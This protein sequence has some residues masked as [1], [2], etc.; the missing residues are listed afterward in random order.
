MKIN[1]KDLEKNQLELTIE[2]S[3]EELE[4]HL[5]NAAERLSHK[6]KIPGFRPGKV[7]YQLIKQHFGEMNI[8]QEALEHIISSSFY[9]AIT[10]EKLETIGQPEIKVDKLAPGNPVVYTAIVSLLPQV[11]LGDWQKIIVK[12]K[13]VKASSEEIEQTLQ[14]LQE[15]NVKETLANRPAAKGDKV[16]VDFEVLINKVV[17]EGGKSSKYPVIIGQNRMIPG[18]EDKLI[19]LKDEDKTEFELEFPAKYFQTNLAGKKADFK[20]KVLNVF[21]RELPKLDD[22]FAK[23]IGFDDLEK[24]KEQLRENISRDKEAKEK[25]RTEAEAV[26]EIV[27]FS[28]IGE[29]PDILIKNEIQKMLYELEHNVRSQSM[30]IAGYLKSINKTREDLEKDFQPQAQERVKAALILRQ[31]AQEENIQSS[32]QEIKE[33]IKKQMELYKDNKE[34]I[35]NIQLPGYRQHTANLINNQKVVKFISEKIIQ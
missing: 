18:F 7:P 3:P 30:D 29:I 16:E 33:Q 23:N 12:K 1:K 35:K 21:S 9:K 13:K 25:Q 17:I 4:P 32:E 24:L 2:V 22:Q 10:R 11:T 14:Q 26:N 5:K 27:K 31:L 28:T 8:H 19:G 15:M 6:N 20:V 34:V